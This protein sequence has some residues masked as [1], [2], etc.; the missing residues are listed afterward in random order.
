MD[1]SL[2]AVERDVLEDLFKDSRKLANYAANGATDEELSAL[3]GV[4]V[5]ALKPF[6]ALLA[7]SRAELNNRIRRALLTAGDGGSPE[8]LAYLAGKYLKGR[9]K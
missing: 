6:A 5:T 2:T 4:P 7:K 3:L 9:G 1:K 8:A